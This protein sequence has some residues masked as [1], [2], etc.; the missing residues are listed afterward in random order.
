M[1]DTMPE[2]YS[3]PRRFPGIDKTVNRFFVAAL[4][5]IIGVIFLVSYKQGLF[6]PHTALYFYAPDALGINKGTTVRLFGLQVGTVK[7]MQISDRGVKV[8]LAIV[9]EYIPRIPKGSHIKLAR[10]SYV[11]GASLQIIP[12][13]GSGATQPV[14]AGDEVGYVT[15]RTIVEI[16]D[17][18]KNQV[19]PLVNDMRGILAEFSRPDGD[20]RKSSAAARELLEQLPATNREAQK[21]LRDTDRTVIAAEATFGSLSRVSAQAE[22]QLPI[23]AGKLTTTLDSFGEAAAQLRE[24]TRKNSDA[25]HETLRQTPALVRDSNDLVRDGQEIVGA[26]RNAWPVRN[27]VEAPATRTLPVDS[28]ETAVAV[29]D[30]PVKPVQR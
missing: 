15:G 5:G 18:L 3:P 13:T 2:S 11:G 23:V 10:E 25:L 29:R 27:L 14:E 26:V 20:Y 9:S 24:A 30:N 21:L 6:I 12:G 4:T 28:F 16:I 8:A 22:Q 17:D 7:D 1:E 19:T